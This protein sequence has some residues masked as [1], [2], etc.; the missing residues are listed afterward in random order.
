[1]FSRVL[2]SVMVHV[3]T[4]CPTHEKEYEQ[5][6]VERRVLSLEESNCEMKVSLLVVQHS[7]SS[8]AECMEIFKGAITTIW[9][10]NSDNRNM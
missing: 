8:M 10:E 6:E 9:E 7:I 3:S 2:R 4:C 5:D 1:M